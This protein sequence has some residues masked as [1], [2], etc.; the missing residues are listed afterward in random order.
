MGVGV[1]GGGLST[2]T[3]PDSVYQL[4]DKFE[5]H[6]PANET[7][8]RRQF[9]DPLFGALGWDVTDSAQVGHEV[10][11]LVDEAG[12][13]KPKRPDYGFRVD[14]DTHF[15]VET[16]PPHLNLKQDSTPAFQLRRYGWSGAKPVS[17]LTDFEEFC[18]YDCRVK[19]Q[20][21][22][23]ASKARLRYYSFTEYTEKWD[24]IAGK[25]SRPAVI[26]GALRRWIGGEATRGMVGV[27]EAFLREMEGWRESLARD[28][29]LHNSQL[30]R[31]DLNLLVQRAID[32]IVFL[33]IAEDRGIE[34]YGR[35]RSAVTPGRAAYSEI[36]RLFH[37]AD[38]KYNSGLFD[39]R[40][41]ALSLRIHI[42]DDALRGIIG[43]LY[44]PESPYEF[45]AVP[46]DILGQVYERFLGKV[47]QLSPGGAVRIE[48]KPEVRK[49]GGVYYTP[50]TIV[51]YIVQ[52]TVG[53]LLDG[54][55]PDEAAKLRVLDPACGSGSFLNGAYQYLLDWHL[56]YY[57]ENPTRYRNRHRHTPDGMI[58]T[59][60]E[61]RR[62][63]LNNIY[64]VDL[65]QSAV[66]VTKL[67]L[68]LKML[69][70]ETD[71]GG[72]QTLMFSA[73]GRI[74]PDLGGNIKWGNSLIGS[75]FY[76]GKQIGFFDEE[77]LYRV[78]AFDWSSAD[79][80]GEIMAA[81]GF[82][83]VI[84]NPPYVRQETLG[85]E[86]KEY[87]KGKF[88]TYAGTA[89]LYTYFIERGVKLLKANGLCGVIVSNKFMRAAYGKPIRRFLRNSTALEQIVDFGE[90]PVFADAATFP[91]IVITR[92]T[93]TSSQSFVY[94]PI[95]SL[96]FK[97]LSGAVSI[98]GN[99]LSEEALENDNWT[100]VPKA[101][102]AILRKM[103]QQGK[104]LRDYLKHR[105]RWGV[106][107]GLNQAFIIT[108]DIKDSL[109]R[110][111]SASGELIRPFAVGDDIRAFRI[112]DRNRYLIF[113]PNGWTDEH[114]GKEGAWT[115][116]RAAYP[117]IAT[118]LSKFE[119]KARERRDQGR[120][121]WEL[122]PCDY[123]HQFFAP[124]LVYPEIA[125][126][127]RFAIDVSGMLT[128]NKTFIV[129]SSDRYLLGILNSRLIWSYL[130]R[131]CSVLGD[132]DRGGR[133]ELRTI[134]M[135]TV[136]IRVIDFDNPDD[137]AMHDQMVSLVDE[138]LDLHRQARD[139]KGEG[140][141]IVDALIGTADGKIDGLVYRLYGLS[142]D[143]IAIVE[144]G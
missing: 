18:V 105:I 88:E 39:F 87:A 120:Y 22:D 93:P 29:A 131:T 20:R 58:L 21:S 111:D 42:S 139:L 45:S 24:D 33:R 30:N 10:S 53:A 13:Q 48:E 16:K 2:M 54:A 23:P 121:W 43:Q 8:L 7:E 122:R 41:D 130:K 38:D 6:K 25:F 28:I 143:E 84:G 135:N 57:R 115:W 68:L 129:A 76:Q 19:P 37:E 26:D 142:D 5:R 77:A 40:Q 141:R 27:D 127:S 15:F 137:V 55:T 79:G 117:A 124:K 59:T 14:G 136:P 35:L 92:N 44:Y 132:P 114:R 83:A 46:A 36:K 74:L 128:N 125:K 91:A 11:V 52:N 65:D 123:Y 140:R 70:N 85:R 61:K 62:I 102:L 109:I 104:P 34:S 94:A 119:S 116:F 78:K 134:Y 133:L 1:W 90:L 110:D 56:A 97:D 100:L 64:G 138:M 126:E 144:G 89:D 4:V 103:R 72:R 112:T 101:E 73:G 106:K 98:V 71:A 108:E 80:F 118:H 95:K 69:E 50:T 67:S 49:A 96:S 60:A 31:R 86:F 113:I 66:E 12:M 3:A 99:H 17:I 75:D 82:D 81:G 9:V 51:D 63:L 32:R 107:T 47:I